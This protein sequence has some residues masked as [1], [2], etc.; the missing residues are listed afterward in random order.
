MAN[1][2]KKETANSH[3]EIEDTA[4]QIDSKLVVDL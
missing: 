1:N 2:K 4:L 3:N